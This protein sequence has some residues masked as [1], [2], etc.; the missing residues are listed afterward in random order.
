M[1]DLTR[2]VLALP[3]RERFRLWKRVGRSL[4]GQVEKTGESTEEVY[5]KYKAQMESIVGYVI[6][7]A[8]RVRPMVYY[9]AM[10]VYK[11]A[12][13]GHTEIAMA[14]CTNTDHATIHYRKE[15]IA[16]LLHFAHMYPEEVA[17]W[18]EFNKK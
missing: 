10:I 1:D 2:A 8:G 18:N 12:L 15:M 14:K 5:K 3:L 13:E 11:M 17:V 9:R 4:E 7:D 16:D 6:P